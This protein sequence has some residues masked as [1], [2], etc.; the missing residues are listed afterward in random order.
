MTPVHGAENHARFLPGQRAGHYESFF[1]RA[2]HPS[3]PLAF[4]IRYTLFSPA[5]R[6]RSMGGTPMPPEEGIG[7][8]WA[9]LFDGETGAHVAVKREVP[10]ARARFARDAFSVQ[11]DD[12]RLDAAALVGAVEAGGHRIAWD[13]RYRGDE[14]PLLLFPRAMYE[15]K[16][17]RAKS[18][19][20]VPMA[21]Y[22]GTLERRRAHPHPRRRRGR[23]GRQPE[24]QLGLA[25][26]R[27]L[28]VG[29]GRRLRHPPG[30]L[31]R[32][33]PPPASSWVRCGR[34]S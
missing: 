29:P 19:V 31:P 21:V 15:A 25:A 9:V 28:R 4:W 30:E 7:E 1:Q 18:L 26:H 3:R 10:I 8:L 16:L 12:A 2:N 27:S 24:P 22:Q 14:P 5:G 20:G 33:S 11:V 13:L 32:D 34:R 17:P 23:V 6:P